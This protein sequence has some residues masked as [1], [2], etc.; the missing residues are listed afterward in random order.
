MNPRQRIRTVME[1]GRPDRVPVSLWLHNFMHEHSAQALADETLRLHE[2]FGFDFYKP[3]SR[4]HCF[5]QMW[6]QQMRPSRAPDDWPAVERHAVRDAADLAQIRALPADGALQ[7]QVEAM[8][9]VR[10]GVGDDVPIVA[11]VF[12]PMM[13]MTLMHAGGMPA[14]LALQREAPDA[15]ER[16]LAAM[17]T[18][19]EDF[20]RRAIDA[21]CDGIFYATTTCNAGQTSRAEYERFHAP[22]DARILQ[23]AA[24]GWMNILHLCGP[25]IHAEWFDAAPTP[26]VSWATTP[27]NPTLAQMQQRAGKTVL[28]GAPGKPQFAAMSAAA[29]RSH[30]RASL[31]AQGGRHHLLG[32]DCSINP[33]TPPELIQAVVDEVRAWTPPSD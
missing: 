27:G 8:R 20:A 29:L 28:G 22:F 33:G 1:G 30:V 31:E 3:Q 4:A 15:L 26:I 14:A 23:A 6:G 11:T 32:P 19:L 10:R 5:G 17:T 9:L 25:A 12:A 24:G 21:G 16:A 18:T 2:R 13:V 7:E